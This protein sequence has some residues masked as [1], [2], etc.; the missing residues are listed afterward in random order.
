MTADQ[1]PEQ[2]STIPAEGRRRRR[3]AKRDVVA[4]HRGQAADPQ[5]INVRGGTG[6]R[7]RV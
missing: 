7:W 3:P 6:I 5:Y 2:R 1:Q 4:H